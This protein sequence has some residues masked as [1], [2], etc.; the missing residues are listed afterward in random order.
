MKEAMIIFMATIIAVIGDI[1]IKKATLA[2]GVNEYIYMGL[3]IFFYAANAIAF[4][5]IYKHTEL[6][7]VGVYY[8]VSTIFLFVLSGIF[9]FGETVSKGELIGIAFGIVS[10]FMLAKFAA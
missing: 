9:L 1:F 5:F 8:A 6:S 7:S 2:K 3:A 4:Y 10:I